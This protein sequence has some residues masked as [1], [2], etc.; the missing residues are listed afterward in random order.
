MKRGEIYYITSNYSETGSEQKGG[1]P[2]VIVSNNINNN[3]SDVVEVCFLTTQ[4]KKDLPT[5]V[6]TRE[7]IMIST[8]LC[9]QITSVSTLRIGDY[10]GKL[11]VSEQAAVDAALAISLGIN[12][13]P[14][15][16]MR[17]PT[18][19]ELE[20]MARAYISKNAPTLPAEIAPAKA[21]EIA[22]AKAPDNAP[23]VG[24]IVTLATLT[25]ERDIYKRLFEDMWRRYM[26]G[27]GE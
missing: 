16:V 13:E 25:T 18:E 2:A 23:D 21:A 11:S 20:K 3:N 8:I 6:T 7:T 26:G 19:E 27:G 24:S 5:H 17:E 9:E 4:P 1:R 22:P 15:T 10:I 14:V 12:P